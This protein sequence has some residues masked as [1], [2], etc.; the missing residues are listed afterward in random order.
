[1]KTI[2]MCMINA[3]STTEDIVETVELLDKIAK[4][5]YSKVLNN[6]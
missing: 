1:M 4:E 5:L 2:R 6:K 3:N